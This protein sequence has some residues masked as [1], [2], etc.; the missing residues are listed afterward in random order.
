L[1]NVSY[2]KFHDAAFLHAKSLEII[3]VSVPPAISCTRL[4]RHS[5]FSYSFPIEIRRQFL[6]LGNL[7]KDRSPVQLE[8]MRHKYM[9]WAISVFGKAEHSLFSTKYKYICNSIHFRS[10][11]LS[12]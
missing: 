4:I 3:S 8:T 7:E 1:K 11:R 2:K 9:R 12:V 10:L 5:A 6:I